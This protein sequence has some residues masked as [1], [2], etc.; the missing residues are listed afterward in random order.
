MKWLR[1]RVSF[2]D[3]VLSLMS[4]KAGIRLIDLGMWAN[5]DKASVRSPTSHTMIRSL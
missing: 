4:A 5:G 3:V 1:Q 2:A